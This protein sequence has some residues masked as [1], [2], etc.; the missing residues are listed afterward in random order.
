MKWLE[1]EDPLK[2]GG[3]KS[4]QMYS[5]LQIDIYEMYHREKA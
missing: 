3:G 1:S 4:D 5:I 2:Y